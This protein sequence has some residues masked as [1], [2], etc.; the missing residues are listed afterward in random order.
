M[1]EVIEKRLEKSVVSPLGKGSRFTA[2][3]DLRAGSIEATGCNEPDD[4]SK[5]QYVGCRV[6]VVDDTATLRM[7]AK[8][9][10]QLLG[11]IVEVADSGMKA[12]ELVA[13]HNYNL[14]LMDC[15]MPL[16]DGLEA[17]CRLLEIN[18]E[19][20]IVAISAH[21]SHQDRLNSLKAGMVSHL[22]KPFSLRDLSGAVKDW[23]SG[24]DGD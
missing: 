21:V 20:R 16:M 9:L 3:P 13:V 4:S 17:A 7:V 22:E 2:K 5:N 10:L 18:P 19:L 6:L 14:I 24:F 12:L 8:E 11:C 15:Q 1:V 23:A